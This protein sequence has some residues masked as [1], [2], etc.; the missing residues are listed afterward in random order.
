VTQLRGA[1]AA[2]I[3]IAFTLCGPLLWLGW[4]ITLEFEAPGSALGADA[5]EAVVHFL[6]EWALIILLLAYAVSP[7]KRLTK[8]SAIA[9]SRRMIGLFAFSYVSLHILSYAYL[10]L[11][12][13]WQSLLEDFIER[14]YIT[15]GMA[16]YSGLLAMACTSTNGWRRRLRRNWQRLH[17]AIYP[18]VGLAL[19]HLLWQTRDGFAEVVL[20]ATVFVALSAERLYRYKRVNRWLHG[21]R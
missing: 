6:G 5:G 19:I 7:L 21:A 10:F 8:S 4:L 2:K 1:A 16:A 3:V 15:V 11:E 17:Y 9:R 14:P 18:A 12:F 13:E 20:Y